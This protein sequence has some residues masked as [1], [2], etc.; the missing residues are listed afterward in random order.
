LENAHGP[1][2]G[3]GFYGLVALPDGWDASVFLSRIFFP[4]L[5]T[6]MSYWKYLLVFEEFTTECFLAYWGLNSG[7]PHIF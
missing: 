3:V 7:G 2:W 5:F 4:L 6:N 1:G